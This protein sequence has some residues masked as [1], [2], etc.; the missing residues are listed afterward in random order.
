MTTAR[1]IYTKPLQRAMA[2]GL[3]MVSAGCVLGPPDR[4]FTKEW[5][6]DQRH[7]RELERRRAYIGTGEWVI[8]EGVDGESRAAVK[9]DERGRPKLHVGGLEGLNIDVD[10]G[11]KPGAKAGYKWEW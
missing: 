9:L 2:V 11:S 6:Q 3:C 7:T 1:S 4:A 8:A 10:L 5:L